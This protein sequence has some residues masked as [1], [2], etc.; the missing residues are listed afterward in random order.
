MKKEYHEV[1]EQYGRGS[2][3]AKM[4]AEALRE[5]LQEIDLDKLSAE[6]RKELETASEQKKSKLVKD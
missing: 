5:L 2:F 4:G 6:I 3:K 1:E